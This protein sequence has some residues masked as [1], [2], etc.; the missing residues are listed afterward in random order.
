M[1]NYELMQTKHAEAQAS[2]EAVAGEIAA[3]RTQRAALA[4]RGTAAAA[5][6]KTLEAAITQA[7][8]V[9]GDIGAFAMTLAALEAELKACQTVGGQLDAKIADAEINLT[10]RYNNLNQAADQMLRAEYL[11]ALQAYAAGIK[12]LLPQA[13]RMLEIAPLIGTSLTPGQ[14]WLINPRSAF[15]G[16]YQVTD[17]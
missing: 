10:R 15:I 4:D 17:L 1:T 6:I 16:G 11:E 14:G 3:M 9:Q 8:L 12:A 13:N 2:A 7:L 5:E